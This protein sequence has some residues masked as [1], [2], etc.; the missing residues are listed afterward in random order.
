[1][2]CLKNNSSIFTFIRCVGIFTTRIVSHF[3][4][5]DGNSANN[6]RHF[7]GLS[8]TCLSHMSVISQE[9][10]R[11]IS[12]ISQAGRTAAPQNQAEIALL[13]NSK[14]NSSIK[15]IIYKNCTLRVPSQHS[16]TAAQQHSNT[17]VQQHSSTAA[18]QHRSTAAQQHRSTAQIHP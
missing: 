13:K 18:Q 1:M 10:H 17:A 14:P 7:S 2:N 6:H 3:A 9:Y 16:R 15:P 5:M 8:Q 4:K 12:S 11:F